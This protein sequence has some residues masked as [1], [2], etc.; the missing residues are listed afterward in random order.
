MEPETT[1]MVVADEIKAG[2]TMPQKVGDKWPNL[3]I[4]KM[5]NREDS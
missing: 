4:I 3:E 2:I 1:T 5:E